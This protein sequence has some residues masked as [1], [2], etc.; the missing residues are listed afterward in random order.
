VCSLG[1]QW[2]TAMSRYKDLIFHEWQF[3]KLIHGFMMIFIG[4]VQH[5][6]KKFG[7]GFTLDIKITTPIQLTPE[8]DAVHK[9]VM[10]KFNP[11]IMKDYHGVSTDRE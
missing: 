2:Q 6:K 1:G 11:C 10:A 4:S 5:L 9:E 7:Q 3:Y 8:Y